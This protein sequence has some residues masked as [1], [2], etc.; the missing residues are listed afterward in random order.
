MF[1][2]AGAL[3]AIGLAAYLWTPSAW[4]K[5]DLTDLNNPFGPERNF[6]GSVSIG[7]S[8]T[9]LA[10]D[11]LSKGHERNPNGEDSWGVVRVDAYFGVYEF[12]W[13]LEPIVAA[14]FL[15]NS[16]P[17][18]RRLYITNA[19]VGARY[20]PYGR[21]LFFVQPFIQSLFRYDFLHLSLRPN[22]TWNGGT[23]GMEFGGGF[24]F[25]F[26]VDATRRDAMQS[27]WGLKDFG[28]MVTSRLIRSG[29]F[30]RPPARHDLGAWDFGLG[31]FIDW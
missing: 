16:T 1:Q 3:L 25:S 21:D 20:K 31:L 5:V 17:R 7:V 11:D 23:F 2:K 18:Y 9:F 22:D 15:T 6:K 27:E 10:D 13:G 19:S 28:M 4:A 8:Q 30:T 24:I 14:G 26:F 12:K 29:W